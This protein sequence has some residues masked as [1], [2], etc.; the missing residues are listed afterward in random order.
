YSETNLNLSTDSEHVALPQVQRGAA[1]IQ[2]CLVR[3]RDANALN[4]APR[5]R[6][7]VASNTN[8]VSG[9]IC[10]IVGLKDWA[11]KNGADSA[12]ALNVL[13][14]QRTASIIRNTKRINFRRLRECP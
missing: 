9:C 5:G 6:V 7:P 2:G 12:L 13:D 3:D 4:E 14:Q 8:N 10:C 1:I 11:C